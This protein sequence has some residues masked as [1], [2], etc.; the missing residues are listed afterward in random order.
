[1]SVK[2]AMN[3]PSVLA[4]VFFILSCAG[5]RSEVSVYRCY[6]TIELYNYSCCAHAAIECIAC[7]QIR[8][9]RKFIGSLHFICRSKGC[10]KRRSF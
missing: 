4:T 5:T 1:L 9:L 10:R 3:F 6:T 8:L 7:S 2:T